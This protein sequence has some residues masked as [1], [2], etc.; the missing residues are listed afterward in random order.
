MQVVTEKVNEMTCQDLANFAAAY[1]GKMGTDTDY[2][3]R[4][5]F[6]QVKTRLQYQPPATSTPTTLGQLVKP[7]TPTTPATIATTPPVTTPAAGIGAPS[8]TPS[9]TEK[10]SSEQSAFVVDLESAL[11][12]ALQTSSISVGDAKVADKANAET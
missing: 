1:S 6:R 10:S 4:N 5:I 2:F 12:A 11:D 9:L 7:P 8:A 3:L